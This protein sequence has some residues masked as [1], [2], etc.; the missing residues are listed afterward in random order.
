MGSIA[1]IFIRR[2]INYQLGKTDMP[3][4]SL[5]SPQRPLPVLLAMLLCEKVIT[6]AETNQKSLI[7]TINQVNSNQFPAP[8]P[9][10]VF[11]RIVDAQGEYDFKFELVH[12]EEDK[13]LGEGTIKG[14]ID[15]RLQTHDLIFKIPL[16]IP[17]EGNYEFRLYSD[18]MYLGRS[19]LKAVQTD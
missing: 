6:D 7:G 15:D 5:D 18:Q 16:V 8:R 11:A 12:L 19:T 2:F 9:L 13:I 1:D 10:V 17:K 3:A 4:E 14:T